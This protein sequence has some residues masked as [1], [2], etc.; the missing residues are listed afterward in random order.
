MALSSRLHYIVAVIIVVPLDF[1]DGQVAPCNFYVLY[2][3][4]TPFKG[5]LQLQGCAT[6][7]SKELMDS[8]GVR[9]F[10]VSLFSLS[11]TDNDTTSPKVISLVV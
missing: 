1:T 10:L 9:S 7:F 8:F 2:N 5:P 11:S 6:F 4:R 3:P